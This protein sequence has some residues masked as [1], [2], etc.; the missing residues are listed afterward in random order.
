LTACTFD[1]FIALAD[2]QESDIKDIESC[3]NERFEELNLKDTDFF[4]Y[5]KTKDCVTLKSRHIKLIRGILNAINNKG[6]ETF[7]KMFQN[8]IDSDIAIP[9][10]IPKY[11]KG[12]TDVLK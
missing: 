7:N 12:T 2:I 9:E 11:V 6:H 8:V 5:Y 10:A 4:I 1:D 3:C